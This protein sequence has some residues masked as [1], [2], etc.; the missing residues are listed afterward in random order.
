MKR[1]DR[2]SKIHDVM[3]G[4]LADLEALRDEVQEGFDNMPENLQSGE[5]GWARQ[6]AATTLDNACT[7]IEAALDDLEGVEFQ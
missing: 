3:R 5:R 6:E 7:E 4:A 1:A 2:L